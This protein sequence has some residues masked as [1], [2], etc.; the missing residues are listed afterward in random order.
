MKNM[1]NVLINKLMGLLQPE[2]VSSSYIIYV[3]LTI[4]G[5]G[6]IPSML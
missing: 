5:Y 4:R 2:K 1:N 3:L 6:F